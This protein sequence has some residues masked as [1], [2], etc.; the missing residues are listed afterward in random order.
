MLACLR[1][2]TNLI[3]KTQQ[4]EGRS[5][6]LGEGA[7]GVLRQVDRT[8]RDARQQER[9][10]E[11]EK[12]AFVLHAIPEGN[13]RHLNAGVSERARETERDI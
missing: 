10:R 12:E 4:P 5:R 2:R 11:T 7:V 3:E 13:N 6:F 8:R 1:E 9:E